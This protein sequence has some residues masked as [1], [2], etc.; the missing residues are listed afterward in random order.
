VPA[1]MYGVKRGTWTSSIMK[2]RDLIY[3]EYKEMKKICGKIKF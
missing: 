3:T 1:M 2:S